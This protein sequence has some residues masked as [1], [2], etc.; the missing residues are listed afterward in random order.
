MDFF[1]F[2]NEYLGFHSLFSKKKLGHI[3]QENTKPPSVSRL[4]T[5]PSMPVLQQLCVV[6]LETNGNDTISK[7]CPG[8]NY[9]KHQEL[10]LRDDAKRMSPGEYTIWGFPNNQ[11]Y[12]L[13][14]HPYTCS[15]NELFITYTYKW[16]IF[17]LHPHLRYITFDPNFNPPNRTSK[18][19]LF[20]VGVGVKKV[21]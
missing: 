15:V 1:F 4:K 13:R 2:R 16:D 11:Y 17:G 7:C 14:K 10:V 19:N 3:K 12:Y 9:L 20:S 6:V 5:L 8:Q 18:R 21:I